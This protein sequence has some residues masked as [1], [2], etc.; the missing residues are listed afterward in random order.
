MIDVKYERFARVNAQPVKFD[1]NGVADVERSLHLQALKIA[2]WAQEKAAEQ[3]ATE[4]EL[5]SFRE[6]MVSKHDDV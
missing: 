5:V 2:W 4:A 1:E 3:A 6:Y